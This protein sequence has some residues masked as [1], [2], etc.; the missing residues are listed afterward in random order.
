MRPFPIT[1]KD[2]P[3]G[4]ARR[5]I[6]RRDRPPS[7]E[8]TAADRPRP[9]SGSSDA[10]TQRAAADDG[11]PETSFHGASKRV[12]R[13]TDRPVRAPSRRTAASIR[14]AGCRAARS[15]RRGDAQRERPLTRRKLG[16]GHAHVV[17]LTRQADPIDSARYKRFGIPRG[18]TFSAAFGGE[19]WVGGPTACAVAPNA[20]MAFSHGRIVR[21]V[22]QPVA[23]SRKRLEA[24]T[25]TR[26]A[27][28]LRQ[29]SRG[30]RPR[31][32]DE[33]VLT[34]NGEGRHAPGTGTVLASLVSQE[35]IP[36]G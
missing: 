7:E 5:K 19:S 2:F 35:R 27:H 14:C 22:A 31:P 32:R 15:A 8:A 34:T 23:R 28:A 18:S 21:L 36:V 26:V 29:G 13:G 4:P 6:W 11:S 30:P 24:C 9:F 25:S 1:A 16:A 12:G 20:L 3:S 33:P 17:R 10:A